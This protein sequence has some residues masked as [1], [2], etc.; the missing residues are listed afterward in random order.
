MDNIEYVDKP[1]NEKELNEMLENTIND[2]NFTLEEL[3]N[4]INLPK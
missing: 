1:F 3:N 4:Q 2:M